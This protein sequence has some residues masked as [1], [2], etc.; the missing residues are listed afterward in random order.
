MRKQKVHHRR[1]REGKTNYYKRLNLLKSKEIRLVIRRSSKYMICQLVQYYP[2]GDKIIMHANSKELEKFG[3]TYSYKNIPSSYLTGAI[4][5]KK[6][7]EKGI[8][9]AILDIGQLQSVKKSRIY[10]IVK[11]AIDSGMKIP[12]NEEV[13]PDEK[14]IKGEHIVNFAKEKKN[15]TIFSKQKDITTLTSKFEEVKKKII[16]K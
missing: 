1:K 7:L 14:R 10:A 11:G 5:A 9:K 15:E 13:F 2:S 8:K 4:I 6:G 16:G 12:C 3:W